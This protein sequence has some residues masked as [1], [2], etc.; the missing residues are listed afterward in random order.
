MRKSRAD[1][2]TSSQISDNPKNHWLKAEFC[3]FLGPAFQLDLSKHMSR[4]R[5]LGSHNR[6]EFN[7]LPPSTEIYLS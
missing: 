6:C 7:F 2:E 4:C 1:F 3:L 5:D